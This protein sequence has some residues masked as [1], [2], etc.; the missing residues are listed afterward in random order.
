MFPFLALSDGP[1][2]EWDHK[3]VNGIHGFFPNTLDTT[4]LACAVSRAP[5]QRAPTQ[6]EG[7]SMFC[8]RRFI[9]VVWVG[10]AL[11]VA[12]LAG[13]A[14]SA[15]SL[16]SPD[17]L[18]VS[19]LAPGVY[20]HFGVNELMNAQNEGAIANVGFVVGADAVAIIDTGGSVREGRA[21]RA[22]VGRVTDKPIKYVINTHGHPDHVFGNA[23]FDA[24][25][26]FVGHRNLPKALAVHGP[27]Y[28]T[29][30]AREMKSALD[31]VK[32]VAPTL[33]VD[34]EVTLD[35]GQRS[36][37]VKAWP[38]SHTDNDLTVFDRTSG[39][40]FAGDLLFAQHVPV[41]DGSILGWLKTIRELARIPATK[42]VPGHGK[43]SEW[44]GALAD[45]RAYLQAL[46]SDCRELIKNGTPLAQAAEIAGAS[47]KGNWELFEAYNKRNATAA[48]S[49]LEWE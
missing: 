24:P 41:L 49:E 37:I 46:V 9:S 30:F 35:L 13:S 23:A 18:P 42:V 6:D 43:A 14:A 44:P 34:D 5:T 31:G 16:E 39:V 21:L 4:A 32:I 17:P 33:I 22:A 20:V 40:L 1:G 19:E 12:A 36:L 26:V 29:A 38:P 11:C 10:M 8:L 48:Y 7:V 45:E 28:I 15:N 25:T 47:Q 2:W 3:I 27:F